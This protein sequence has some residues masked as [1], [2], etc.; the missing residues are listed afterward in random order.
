MRSGQFPVEP[1]HWEIEFPE[2]FDKELPG[3]DAI[4][5]NP[6]YAGHY[7][8]SS[9]NHDLYSTLLHIL[10]SE[11]GGKCDLVAFFFRRSFSVLLD[12]GVFG[13]L[14]TKSIAQGDTRQSGLRFLCKNGGTIF[15]V[16]SRVAWPGQAQVFVTSVC[17]QKRGGPT[18]P[19][20]DGKSVKRISAYLKE[21][22]IDESPFR[23]DQKRAFTSYQ[24]CVLRGDG[25]LFEDGNSGA[26]AI[27]ERDEIIQSEPQYTKVIRRLLGVEDFY[28]GSSSARYAIFFANWAFEKV[29]AW[30]KALRILENKVLGYRESLTAKSAK[31][32]AQ[33][34][35]WQ[36]N[37]P[38]AELHAELMRIGS[39]FCTAKTSSTFA[40]ARVS[41][42]V[43]LS[44]S[45]IGF[46]TDSWAF[47]SIMQSRV[48]EHWARF[49][50][51][52]LKNDPRYTPSECFDTFPF[53][54]C[55]ENIAAL[56]AIG[57]EYYQFRDTIIRDMCVGLTFI[58]N[59]FHAPLK[60]AEANI[61]KLYSKR[62]T[63]SDRRK[64]EVFSDG[65]QAMTVYPTPELAMEGIWKLRD[66]HGKMDEG[67]LRAY[68]W[69][70]LAEL[71]E[72][73]F[74]LDY[75]DEDDADEENRR[76][77]KKPWHYRWSDEFRDEVLAR[78]LKL[79]AER[80]EEEKIAGL[81]AATKIPKPGKRSTTN[82]KKV[83]PT[84]PVAG[85][86]A[87]GA[88]PVR[89]LPT[90]FR[91][92][93]S[94]PLLY[95]TNLVVAIL[96]EAGGSLSWSK[97]LDAFILVTHPK[98]ALRLAPTEEAETVRAWASRW[99]ESLTDGLL[100]PSL[101]QLGAKNLTVTDTDGVFEFHLL[102]GPRKPA[103]E[104]LAYD[105]WLGL[106]LAMIL[107][108]EV[109]PIPERINW[110]KEARELILA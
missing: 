22:P 32:H 8:L 94:Q 4:V 16:V 68:G 51:S 31:G 85:T 93:V 52:S 3:F 27:S 78:L 7:T 20:L 34:K 63:T 75:E 25:F 2:V 44:Q 24:G 64:S 109:V 79:N 100:L 80:A 84:K 81:N 15:N 41:G 46:T 110:T 19:I 98:L 76:T 6:P 106:R 12:G 92:P 91:W 66:F 1:F 70:D 13:L 103:T 55:F 95:T 35:W 82:A 11:S 26:S 105:A 74:L 104:D 39:L 30:P 10:Y 42:D 37:Y 43:L 65:S 23:I 73:E 102:D 61:C 29:Q 77:R 38:S 9:G 62:R 36:F 107:T 97:L 17:V 90:D 101:N 56:N 86:V 47:F 53:P 57:R 33:E 89:R 96:S 48:H 18:S 50:S 28:D 67:V 69:T 49:F 71:A 88:T 54:E 72:C 108:P 99:N 45:L 87:P 59:L 21:F 14:A 60:E 83:E 58:Y 40:F 5:G